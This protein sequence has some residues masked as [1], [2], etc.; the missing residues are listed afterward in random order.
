MKAVLWL[1]RNEVN[2]LKNELKVRFSKGR[3]LF[4]GDKGKYWKVPRT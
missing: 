1:S 4:L 2:L 3:L